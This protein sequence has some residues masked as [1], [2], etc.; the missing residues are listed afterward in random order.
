[1][2]NI[3]ILS[4]LA[5]TNEFT[6]NLIKQKIQYHMATSCDRD[7]FLEKIID[8]WKGSNNLN[9]LLAAVYYHRQQ[10]DPKRNLF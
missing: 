8:C 7:N 5:K 4:P 3:R 9:N 6:N 10:F 2:A 1:M